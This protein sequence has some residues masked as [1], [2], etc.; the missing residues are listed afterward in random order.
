MF[1]LAEFYFKCCSQSYDVMAPQ[2]TMTLPLF[3]FA[4][5]NFMICLTDMICK[6][7]KVVEM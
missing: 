4:T 6:K 5:S 1:L 7:E 2:R 3:D